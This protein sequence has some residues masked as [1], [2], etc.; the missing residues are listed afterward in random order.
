MQHLVFYLHSLGGALYAANTIKYCYAR[1]QRI[2]SDILKS[3]LNKVY[4]DESI[5]QSGRRFEA[6]E[7][8]LA[9]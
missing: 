2:K 4:L 6:S 1:Q 7:W 3:N 5:G 8:F 9:G